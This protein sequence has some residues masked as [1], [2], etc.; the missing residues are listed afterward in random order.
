MNIC[1]YSCR[2]PERSWIWR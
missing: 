1:I 2:A